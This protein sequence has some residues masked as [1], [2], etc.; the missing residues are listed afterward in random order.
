MLNKYIIS[1]LLVLFGELILIISF[2]HF[3]NTKDTDILYLNIVVSSIIYLLFFRGTI[4]AW[5]GVSSNYENRIGS[6]GVI[7]FFVFLYSILAILVMTFSNG[8]DKASFDNQLIYQ[9]IVFFLLLLGFF[10]SSRVNEKEKSVSDIDT[11]NMSYINQIKKIARQINNELTTRG[12]IDITSNA[13]YSLKKLIDDIKYLY[14]N[15]SLS[16]KNNETSLINNMN[17]II[18]LL[19]NQ[20]IDYNSLSLLVNSSHALYTEIKNTYSI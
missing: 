1:Y 17:K 19:K 2:F 8:H 6:L 5:M 12:D 7:W 16:G 14:P 9:S 15:N 20:T 10:L 18:E 4:S 11:Q 3:G 13:I